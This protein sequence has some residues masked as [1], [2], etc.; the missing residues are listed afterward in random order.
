MIISVAMLALLATAATPYLENTIKRQKEAELRRSLREIRTAIDAYKR[1]Y[2]EGKM[3]KVVGESGYP[4]TLEVL[5]EGV[6]DI[7]DPQKRKLRFLR[8]L[9]PDPMFAGEAAKA[10]IT[11][12]KRAYDSD[13]EN[14]REGL[15]V[16]DVYSL[17]D[18]KGMNGIPYRQW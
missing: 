3:T 9:P 6:V 5:T 17:S 16:F 18:E 13:S 12:G 11:W 10:E 8:K 4:K 7:T 15:D 2:D 1:A 14:P